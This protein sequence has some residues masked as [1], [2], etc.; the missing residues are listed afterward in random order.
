MADEFYAV[1]YRAT[2]DE[3]EEPPSPTLPKDDDLGGELVHHYEKA[4]QRYL[5]SYEQH[6]NPNAPPPLPRTPSPLYLS[7]EVGG[8]ERGSS[9]E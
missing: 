7:L 1:P 5:H 9:S 3:E 8:G 2:F 6:Q 4:F